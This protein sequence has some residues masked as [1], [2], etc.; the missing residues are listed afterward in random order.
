[1]F[2]RR[3]SGGGDMLRWFRSGI[4][5]RRYIH[6]IKPDILHAHQ[7]TGAGWL[8]WFA[9][10]HPY[11]VMPWGSDLYQL[12]ERSRRAKWL[13]QRV[14]R[15]SDLTLANSGHL[16]NTAIDFGADPDGAEVVQWGVNFDVFHPSADRASVRS[17]FE[18]PQ[19]PIILNPRPIRPLYRHD[20]ALRAINRTKKVFPEVIFVFR[21][22]GAASP[23]YITD[24]KR[25]A[26]ELDVFDS[27][28]ILGPFT[29]QEEV[30]R[31]YQAA[32]LVVS[33]PETDGTAMSVLE[34]FACFVP[35]ISSDVP[36]MREWIINEITGMLVPV[37]DEQ[38]LTDSIVRLLQDATMQTQIKQNAL[39]L[40]R[41]KADHFESMAR[42]EKLYS[43]LVEDG[44]NS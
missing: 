18:L 27:I 35:V 14:L 39:R 26:Q 10:Y 20:V 41:E 17:Q 44:R 15:S 23:S 21:D 38:A 28:R 36:T 32:D 25:Q 43:R 34:S 6:Q 42:V 24:L 40:V 16:L 13:A 31:L 19:G 8:G 5:I 22:Y 29:S 2:Y 4:S 7:V 1:M 12:P 37:G 9:S 30:S 3:V 33:I 11:V